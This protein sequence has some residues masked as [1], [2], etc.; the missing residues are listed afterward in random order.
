LLIRLLRETIGQ[1]LAEVALLVMLVS[2]VAV[3]AAQEFACSLNCTFEIAT[4]I[5]DKAQG[6]IPPGQL[7]KCSKKC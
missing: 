2:L 7:K 5:L 3:A 1:N 4:T 6:K